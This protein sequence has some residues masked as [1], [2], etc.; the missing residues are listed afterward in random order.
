ME[1]WEQGKWGV[2]KYHFKIVF[3]YSFQKD[4]QRMVLN[5]LNQCVIYLRTQEVFFRFPETEPLG[6]IVRGLYFCL[7]RQRFFSVRCI[8]LIA[9]TLSCKIANERVETERKKIIH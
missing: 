4:F 3:L 9:W 1:L 8:H 6:L 5:M 7:T 2:L